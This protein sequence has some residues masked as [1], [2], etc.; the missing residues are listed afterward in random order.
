MQ[1]LKNKKLWTYNFG[2]NL[3]RVMSELGVT[4][5]ELSRRTEMRQSTI[6][7][8]INGDYTPSI[9]SVIA[10]AQ[11]L[12]V[13]YFV[14]LDVDGDVDIRTCERDPEDTISEVDWLEDFSWRLR[15]LLNSEDVS[16]TY[17]SEL[18]GLSQSLISKYIKGQTIPSAYAVAI[19]AEV[20]AYNDDYD[21]L[22]DFGFVSINRHY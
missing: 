17:L 1:L 19:I 5:R 20:M 3:R 22:L 16:Q 7:A 9:T 21:D 10:M 6:S 18:T 15:S 4:Q 12:G 8:Y 13:E 11:A 2:S 14:L